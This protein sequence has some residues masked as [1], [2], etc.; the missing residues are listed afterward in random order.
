MIESKFYNVSPVSEKDALDVSSNAQR[1]ILGI[2]VGGRYNFYRQTSDFLRLLNSSR[3]TKHDVD[4]MLKIA[5][6]IGKD[7][8]RRREMILE[9]SQNAQEPL[10]GRPNLHDDLRRAQSNPVLASFAMSVLSMLAAKPFAFM[11]GPLRRHDLLPYLREKE[12]E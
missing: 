7:M 10:A 6:Y 1:T 8:A 5:R 4:E 12:P 2:F 11:Y 9:Q 3:V